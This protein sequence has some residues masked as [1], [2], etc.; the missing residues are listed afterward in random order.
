[1]YL[2]NIEPERIRRLD[3]SKRLFFC[4]SYIFQ[5]TI[6]VYSAVKRAKQEQEQE[7]IDITPEEQ[8]EVTLK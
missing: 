2:V 4:L 6:R 1:M 5:V 8:P 7:V 3:F